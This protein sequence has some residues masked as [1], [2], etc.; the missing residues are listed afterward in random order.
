MRIGAVLYERGGGRTVARLA[1]GSAAIHRRVGD[2]PRW[3][4][5][6]WGEAPQ[7]PDRWCLAA[8]FCRRENGVD[9]KNSPTLD[10]GS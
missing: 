5:F 1:D 2:I 8:H 10:I 7:H 4:V 6:D 3:S 9:L